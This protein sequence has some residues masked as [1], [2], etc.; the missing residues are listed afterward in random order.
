MLGRGCELFGEGLVLLFQL[1]LGGL[2]RGFFGLG[3]T[4]LQ[5]GGPETFTQFGFGGADLRRGQDVADESEGESEREGKT[6]HD[7]SP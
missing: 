6:V 4:E 1:R 5:H 7:Q 2:Q 3:R